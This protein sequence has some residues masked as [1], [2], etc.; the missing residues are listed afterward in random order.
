MF[1]F[2]IYERIN[3]INN[4]KKYFVYLLW[5]FFWIIFFIVIVND[6]INIGFFFENLSI[7]YLLCVFFV[8][9]IYLSVIFFIFGLGYIG[10]IEVK[11]VIV[12]NID[13]CFIE[14]VEINN[15]FWFYLKLVFW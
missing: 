10:M 15:F 12:C 9:W 6:G 4:W 7:D 5:Y 13:I 14:N 11:I 3:I 8:D 2:V 1:K